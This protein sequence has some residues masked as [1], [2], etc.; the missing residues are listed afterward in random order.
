[1]HLFNINTAK[2]ASAFKCFDSKI[3]RAEPS[4]NTKETTTQNIASAV[5]K[6]TR[7]AVKLDELTRMLNNLKGHGIIKTGHLKDPR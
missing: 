5:E 3:A 7:K 4:Q 2:P 1:V 6:T